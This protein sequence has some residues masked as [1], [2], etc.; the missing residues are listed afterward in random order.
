MFMSSRF[1]FALLICLVGATLCFGQNYYVYV[2]AESEDQVALIQFDG[3]TA[4]V[5]KTIPVGVKPTEIEGPHGITVSPDGKHWFLSLAHGNPF[6]YLLKYET[7]TDKVV[8]E[9]TLGLFPASMQI[10]EA[11][12]LLFCVNFN[13]HGDMVPSTISVVEPE[14]MS[15]MERIPVGIMPHGS[16]ISPDGTR[17][18]TVGMMSG[19]LFEINTLTLEV[20]RVLNLDKNEPVQAHT[21]KAMTGHENH[22]AG[23]AMNDMQGHHHSAIKPTWVMPHPDG[24]RVYVAA[25]GSN[26]ILEIDLETWKITHKMPCGKGPYNLDVSPD[27]TKLIVSYKSEG[28]TG[29]W[30]LQ[31]RKELAHIPNTRKVTHGVAVSPD[32]KY[33]FISVE[34]IGGESGTMDVIDLRTLERVATAEL[35]KQAG[36]IAFWKIE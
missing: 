13:L 11:S 12:G 30:D 3:E 9:T 28:S 23:H 19:E 2:T 14:T 18:Y 15:E 34:G 29:I 26:E 31:N 22:H 35:G 16:R 6:G 5:V 7:G 25:N 36:G 10:S 17:Q 1:F 20:A 27:G 24:K 21:D 33:A 4:N 8:G 32:S